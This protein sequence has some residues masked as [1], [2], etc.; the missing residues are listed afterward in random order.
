MLLLLRHIWHRGSI[1][2]VK[3]FKWLRTD[4]K[5]GKWTFKGHDMGKQEE[6]E[7]KWVNPHT[8]SQ[9]HNFS[10]TEQMS[11]LQI[12]YFR[13]GS[14]HQNVP[15]NYFLNEAGLNSTDIMQL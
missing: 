7:L 13:T 1:L 4:G 2:I 8:F 15:I 14:V 3:K 6:N 11:P 12:Y 9:I 5:H 10:Y